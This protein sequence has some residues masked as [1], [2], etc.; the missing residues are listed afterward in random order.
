MQS[1]EYVA[2]LPATEP[3]EVASRGANKP[4]RSSVEKPNDG[5]VPA[6]MDTAT[7]DSS[8]RHYSNLISRLRRMF[9]GGGLPGVH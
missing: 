3:W 6:P 5:T 7:N 1:A 8:F 9:E 2:S 4:P